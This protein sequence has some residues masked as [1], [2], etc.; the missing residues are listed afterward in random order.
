[1]TTGD[2]T[3]SLRDSILDLLL[4]AP[5]GLA[6]DAEEL[7]PDL[8]RRGRNHALAARRIGEFAVLAGRR[9][10]EQ[11]LAQLAED[12]STSSAP[13]PAASPTDLAVPAAVADEER[14]DDALGPGPGHD[15][16]ETDG[17]TSRRSADPESGESSG[18]ADGATSAVPS[19]DDLA[20]PD[21]DLLAASQVVKRLDALTALQLEDV[22][23]YEDATRGRRTIL[24]KIARLQA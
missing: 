7:A 3:P 11:A 22:R 8:A 19:V 1:M 5:I 6:L 10:I 20:I 13:A 4:Y 14:D 18:D 15:G 16:I 21:Y 23:R 17:D 9:R 24:H 12:P 2:R